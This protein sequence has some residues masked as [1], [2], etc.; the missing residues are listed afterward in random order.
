MKLEDPATIRTLW[1]V[2]LV[3]LALLAAADVFVHHHAHFDV[4]GY[5]GFYSGYGL[6]VCVAMVLFSK[7]VVGLVLKRRDTYYDD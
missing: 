4:D 1:I 5:P 6:L 3:V 2:A 7:F